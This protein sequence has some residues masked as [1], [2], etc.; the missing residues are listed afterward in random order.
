MPVYKEACLIDESLPFFFYWNAT[1]QSSW[2]ISYKICI[3]KIKVFCQFE[4][5][6]IIF[7]IFYIRSRASTIIMLFPRMT[8]KNFKLFTGSQSSFLI[9]LQ[10]CQFHVSFHPCKLPVTHQRRHSWR[11]QNHVGFHERICLH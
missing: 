7:G 2:K 9:Y 3:K 8:Y 6:F 5:F 11:D 1:N 4:L 10:P